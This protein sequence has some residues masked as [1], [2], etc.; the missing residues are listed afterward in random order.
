ML[1]QTSPSRSWMTQPKR[2]RRRGGPEG[3]AHRVVGAALVSAGLAFSASLYP[4]PSPLHLFDGSPPKHELSE[5]PK[6]ADVKFLNHKLPNFSTLEL[7]DLVKLVELWNQNFPDFPTDAL[8][9]LVKTYGLPDLVKSLELLKSFE[10]LTHIVPGFSGGGGGGSP[11]VPTDVLAALPMLLEFLKQNLPDSLGHGLSDVLTNVVQ[12]LGIPHTAAGPL[13]EAQ[14]SALAEARVSTPA[15]TPVSAPADAPVSAPTEA[16]VSSLPET[17][18]P[19][20]DLPKIGLPKIGLP[21][22]GLPKIGLPKLDAQSPEGAPAGSS[23]GGSAG[24]SSGGSAGSS[25]G[26]SA[27]SSSGGSAGSSSGGSAGSS[28]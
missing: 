23:S 18:D 9:D 12:S 24:S 28:S 15:D 13:P 11:G 2:G 16:P 22:I 20:P 21:K 26:G 14:V 3:S 7:P 4:V 5:F 27:G 19:A 17:G 1:D 6:L 10:P 25:S 8:L